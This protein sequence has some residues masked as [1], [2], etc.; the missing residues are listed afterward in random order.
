MPLRQTGAICLLPRC[1]TRRSA[2][3][4]NA[5]PS[6]RSRQPRPRRLRSES[7]PAAHRR[8]SVGGCAGSLGR[9]RSSTIGRTHRALCRACSREVS[10]QPFERVQRVGLACC[11]SAHPSRLIAPAINDLG[12]RNFGYSYLRW[13]FHYSS[14][15]L[16]VVTMATSAIRENAE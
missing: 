8:Y 12:R 7:S 10:A 13:N 3:S 16:L 9:L 2:A 1:S 5:P 4:M 14:E 15:L 6:G 11:Y